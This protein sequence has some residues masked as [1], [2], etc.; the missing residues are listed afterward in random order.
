VLK[1]PETMDFYRKQREDF[2]GGRPLWGDTAR[3]MG[4]WP[5]ATA[6]ELSDERMA[7]LKEEL[8][9]RGLE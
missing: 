2:D 8:K 3:M 6:E 9:R 5:D 7:V 1:G 4:E